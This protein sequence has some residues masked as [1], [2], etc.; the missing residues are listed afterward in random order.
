MFD[1][2]IFFKYKT[3]HMKATTTKQK[4]KLGP[5]YLNRRGSLEENDSD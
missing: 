4:S 5:T 2:I 1:K 3:R